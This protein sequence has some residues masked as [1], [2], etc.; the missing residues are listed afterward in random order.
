[1]FVEVAVIGAAGCGKLIENETLI[2][3][4]GG[5]TDACQ[6]NLFLLMEWTSWQD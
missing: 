6:W 3:V 4:E 5:F 1:M 2:E